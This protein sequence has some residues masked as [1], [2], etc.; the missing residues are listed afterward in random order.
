MKQVISGILLVS[1]LGSFDAHSA[2]FVDW[3]ANVAEKVGNAV[4]GALNHLDNPDGIN[5]E[6]DNKTGKELKTAS[7]GRGQN[8]LERCVEA[9]T[10]MVC[11]TVPTMTIFA[12]KK[13]TLMYREI[14]VPRGKTFKFKVL[15]RSGLTFSRCEIES[16]TRGETYRFI[17][18]NSGLLGKI[19]CRPI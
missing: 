16:A 5:V 19:S 13:T 11:P 3:V 17:V 2:G 9:A 4:D 10:D 15:V 7:T 1:A 12:G 14:S 18:D 8:S 6:I